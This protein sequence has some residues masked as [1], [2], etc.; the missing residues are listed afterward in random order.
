VGCCVLVLTG[1]PITNK[2]LDKADAVFDDLPGVSSALVN[3]Q[4]CADCN[5]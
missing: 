2:D 3:N 4:L 1:H 5:G